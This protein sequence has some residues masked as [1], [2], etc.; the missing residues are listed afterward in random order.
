M[1]KIRRTGNQNKPNWRFYNK[2]Q[3][4]NPEYQLA[5]GLAAEYTDIVGMDCTYYINDTTVEADPLYGEKMDVEYETGMPTKVIFEIAEIPTIYTLFGVMAQDTIVAFIPRSVYKRDVSQ[6]QPPK[7][8]DVLKVPLYPS[9]FLDNFSSGGRTFEIIH[10]AQDTSIFM[11]RSLV[12]VFNLVPYRY[13]EES[14]SAAEVA[15]DI[16]TLSPHIS[17]F[18][19][20]EWIDDNKDL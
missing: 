3:D 6:T 5:E 7:I 20:N 11:Y 19:D 13:S 18:G 8:G 14:T 16:S 12:Y 15:S 4:D 17:A 2:P 1:A 9:D 10:V